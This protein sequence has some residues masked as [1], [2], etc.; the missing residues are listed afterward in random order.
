MPIKKIIAW[1][2]NSFIDFPGTVSTVLFFSG[3]NLRCPYCHN[4]KIV[5]DC[6]PPIDYDEFLSFLDKR[7]GLIDGVV[8]TGG[9]PTL[10]NL[11]RILHDIKSRNYKIKLDTNGLLLREN[12]NL[13]KD[14]DYLALDVKTSPNLYI[15]ILKSPYCDNKERL[16]KAIEISKTIKSEIRTTLI[17][18]LIN[19]NICHEIG[20][21]IE[22][23][24]Q[25]YLQKQNMFAKNMLSESYM[26]KLEP[27]TDEEINK[28]VTILSQYVKKCTV[29]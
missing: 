15:D 2:R 24:E 3:C 23:S 9:E 21:L 18:G 11:T 13:L 20:K 5:H 29:R 6:Y 4:V 14:I 8:I 22:G 25:L 26:E 1:Q 10:R 16:Q 12:E 17:R 27:F 28:F 7:E 19:E